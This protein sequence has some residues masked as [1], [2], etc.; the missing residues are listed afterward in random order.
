[1]A[2]DHL[3]PFADAAQHAESTSLRVHCNAPTMETAKYGNVSVIDAA[4][5]RDELTGVTTLFMVNRTEEPVE[6]AVPCG[7]LQATQVSAHGIWD[8]DPSAANTLE[9]PERVGRRSLD[10]QFDSKT[11]EVRLTLPPISWVVVRLETESGQVA[12]TA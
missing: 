11:H 5:T 6:V 3:F 1:M 7:A 12:A 2:A 8:A 10:A 9:D 4:A